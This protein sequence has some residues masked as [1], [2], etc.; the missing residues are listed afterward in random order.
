[1]A[2]E[3]TF[4]TDAQS[5]EFERASVYSNFI[6][7]QGS[8]QFRG[9]FNGRYT[10]SSLESDNLSADYIARGLKSGS[11]VDKIWDANPA[12]GGPIV[13]D[14]M[15]IYAGYRHWGTYNTVAGSFKD[16]SFTEFPYYSCAPDGSGACTNEQQLVPEVL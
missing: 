8:N 5:A 3:I 11:K 9:F 6:P 2:Q 13:K 15:W 14:R 4:Q 16:A 12:G 1:M 10:N 7:E